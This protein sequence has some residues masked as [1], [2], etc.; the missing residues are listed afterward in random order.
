LLAYAVTMEAQITATLN[1]MPNGVDE[2]TLRNDSAIA[3]VAFAVTA[4]QFP[5]TDFASGAPVVF[6]SDPLIEPENKPLP[7]NEE[8]TV[9]RIAT[10]RRSWEPD[11][12]ARRVLEG[13]VVA[14]GVLADGTTTGDAALLTRLILRR[15]NTLLAVETSIETLSEAG[16]R[17]I[18]RNQLIEQFQKMA[19]SM[20]RWYVPVE[21]QVG[22]EVYQSIMGRLLNLPPAEPGA[23]FPPA[24]FIAS[25]TASLNRRRVS[26]LESQP[27]LEDAVLVVS[28]H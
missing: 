6:Y 23:A 10:P 26:L 27:G 16:R 19:D 4:K 21:Q 7:A 20:N 8:R 24:A 15:S 1:H 2:V 5:R 22:R 9:M 12:N 11:P 17:N 14:A 13:T 25:E 3:V 18:P 28:A